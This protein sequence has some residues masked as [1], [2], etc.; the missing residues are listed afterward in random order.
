MVEELM[1]FINSVVIG[2]KTDNMYYIGKTLDDNL[3]QIKRELG[4]VADEQ[5]DVTLF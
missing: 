3:Y 5:S 4:L 1:K 2:G